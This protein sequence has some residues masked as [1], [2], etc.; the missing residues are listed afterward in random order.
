[1]EDLTPKVTLR[2]TLLLNLDGTVRKSKSG[3][4]FIQDAEDMEIYNPLVE[5]VVW[6]YKIRGFMIF[7]VTNQGGVA[8]GYKKLAD[9]L[10]ESIATQKLFKR[11]PFDFIFYC[12]HDPK[13]NKV[14]FNTRSL[15]RKPY[16]GMAVQAEL[17]AREHAGIILDWDNS[18]MIGDRPEDRD[19]AKA[20]SVK[21]LHP[22][23]AFTLTHLQSLR[24]NFVVP[25]KRM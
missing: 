13:G 1:M 11:N 8:H 21:Y 12:A 6:Q 2:P 25:V 5:E 24:E 22:D 3:H 23:E 20:I 9:I 14:P 19:M 16:Y 4:T 7:G 18:V 15:L 17:M 10:P